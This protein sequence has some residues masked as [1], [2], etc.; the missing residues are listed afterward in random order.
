MTI[1]PSDF[2]IDGGISSFL[3]PLTHIFLCCHTLSIPL[4]LI[5]YIIVHLSIHHPIPNIC[6]FPLYTFHFCVSLSLPHSCL[7][8]S[9]ALTFFNRIL[10][11]STYRINKYKADLKNFYFKF[12]LSC[13]HMANWIDLLPCSSIC[14][15]LR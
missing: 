10:L 12:W 15:R 13:S 2:S 8:F 6:L 1:L 11:H 3:F 9:A 5:S 14:T 7:I 4:N